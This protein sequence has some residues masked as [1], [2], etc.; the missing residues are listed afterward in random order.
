M[1][2]GVFQKKVTPV[3]ERLMRRTVID[4]RTGCINWIGSTAFGGHGQLR[5]KNKRSVAAHRVSWEHHNGPIP[6]GMK[7]CHHCDNPP[8][9]NP[10][11]LFLGTQADNMRDMI[12]K[13]RNRRGAT[14]HNAKLS[15]ARVI[16]IILANGTQREIAKQF[17]VSQTYVGQL[18]QGLR[19]KMAR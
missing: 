16:E 13:G 6:A 17:G 10:D 15:D 4:E 18:K 11:H 2:R 3:Y 8:C 5:T 19:R 14:H 1:P 9:V 7:V 12:K